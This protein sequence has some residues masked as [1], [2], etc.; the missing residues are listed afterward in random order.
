MTKERIAKVEKWIAALRSGKYRQTTGELATEVRYENG[1]KAYKFCCLG[2]MCMVNR[3]KANAYEMVGSTMPKDEEN[4]D[5]GISYA[6]ANYLT[7]LNDEKGLKFS[8][9]ANELE[10]A[11]ASAIKHRRKFVTVQDFE[12]GEDF[13]RDNGF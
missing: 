10:K 9:I 7:H 6:S 12:G 4:E 5:G 11:L 3:K 13:A 2:V 8:K 1:K